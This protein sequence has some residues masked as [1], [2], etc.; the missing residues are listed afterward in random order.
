MIGCRSSARCACERCRK[1]VTAQIVMCVTTSVN[2]QHLPPGG[3]SRPL[4]QPL[5]ERVMHSHMNPSVFLVNFGQGA[6]GSAIV[7][8][9]ATTGTDCGNCLDQRGPSSALR[10]V[11][12]RSPRS[13]IKAFRPSIS[14]V[15]R[16]RQKS[17]RCGGGAATAA[18]RGRPPAP[19]RLVHTPRPA[20]RAAGHRQRLKLAPVRGREGLGHHARF[21]APAGCRWR[22]PA[23]RPA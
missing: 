16:R 9:L 8:A 7:G 19:R 21:P 14:A 18:G 11:W 13:R 6:W 10:Q 20:D 12:C 22:R 5:H 2:H 23:A 1:M 3:S 15:A 4:R 17:R